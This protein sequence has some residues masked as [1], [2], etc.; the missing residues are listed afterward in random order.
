[1]EKENEGG[2]WAAGRKR[3]E[4]RWAAGW[5]GKGVWGC[6]SFFFKSFLTKF[7]NLFKFKFLHNCLANFS[8]TFLQLF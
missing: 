2:D 4:G 1:V 6:F 5:V 7:L 8:Q 3:R